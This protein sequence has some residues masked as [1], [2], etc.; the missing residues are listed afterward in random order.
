[1]R[2]IHA[3]TIDI[4][5]FTGAEIP[6]YAIL[7]HIWTAWEVSFVDM[8]EHHKAAISKAGFNKIKMCCQK[9]ASDG[10]GYV[11]IDT[12]CIDKSSSAELS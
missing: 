2:L 11:W 3:F 12:C 10:F 8:Q 9:A 6:P 7:S 1:M 4:Y 5:E